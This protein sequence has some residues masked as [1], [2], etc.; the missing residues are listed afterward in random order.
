MTSAA[1]DAPV[2]PRALHLPAAG[3][4]VVVTAL[5]GGLPLALGDA[6]RVAAVAVL[7]VALVAAWPAITGLRGPVG[8]L[9]VGTAAA[10]AADLAVLLP[11]RPQLDALAPV[12]GLGLLAAV[13][14]QMT[15]PAPRPELVPS[16]ASVVLL[17]CA[18]C[19]LAPLLAV[20]RLDDGAR[21]VLATAVVVGAAL[22][23]GHLVD[24][25]LPR[26]A[27]APGVPCGLVALV[28]AVLAGGAAAGVLL[29]DGGS[30]ADAV[31]AVTFG[32]AL[33][34]VAALTSL[35]ASYLVVER[36]GPGWAAAVV[37]A[38]LPMA[39]AA[40]VAFALALNGVG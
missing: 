12:L 27:V 7:Q 34:A 3:L 6:G 11:E 9:V 28:L 20:G 4:A 8:A 2:S 18:V 24:L 14:H 1:P 17:V 38:V 29:A 31:A 23:V 10:A 15:R 37:Q 22:V 36:A 35:A 16:L 39:A 32:A 5:L 40:P 25:V 21:A 19:A 13:L 33:G 26:P 30:P